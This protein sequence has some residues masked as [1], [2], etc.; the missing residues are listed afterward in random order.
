MFLANTLIYDGIREIWFSCKSMFIIC[1]LDNDRRAIV[2]GSIHEIQSQGYYS[3]HKTR[4]CAATR[5]DRTVF[6]IAYF[7]ASVKP[8]FTVS[9]Y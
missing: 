3:Y 5:P 8:D 4:T 7:M 9:P 6:L 2:Q 1:A